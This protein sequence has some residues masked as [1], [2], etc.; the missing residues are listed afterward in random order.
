M[1]NPVRAAV[2]R[3]FEAGRLLRMGGPMHGGAALEVGCGRGVGAEIVLDSFGADTVDGFDLDP[4]MVAQARARLAPRGAR[5]RFWVGD[6]TAIP[7]PDASYDAVFDFGIIHHVPD[8]RRALAEVRRVLKPGGRLYAE[9]VLDRFILNPVVR[10]V[11]DHPEDD[12][13]DRAGFSAALAEAGLD[14][15]DERDLLGWFGWFVAIKRL[16]A[17][18]GTG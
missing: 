7:V 14:P 13:F 11:L 1:N 6:A 5:A 2:Q 18:A 16:D 9:E 4:R 10:R 17:R 8:W 12:R 15:A 3:R